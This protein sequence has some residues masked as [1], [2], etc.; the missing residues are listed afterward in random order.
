MRGFINKLTCLPQGARVSEPR[1]NWVGRDLR[2]SRRDA[3]QFSPQSDSRGEDRATAVLT[4]KTP[5][6]ATRSEAGA[7]DSN[8]AQRNGNRKDNFAKQNNERREWFT[9][10]G[11]ARRAWTQPYAA[12][13]RLWFF[14]VWSRQRR[15]AFYFSN[16]W[17]RVESRP[18]PRMLG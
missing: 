16:V 12:W 2:A 11:R 15:C 3:D 5:L 1:K 7:C 9:R 6:G 8:E 18:Y 10:E 14:K 17:N 13:A 4:A